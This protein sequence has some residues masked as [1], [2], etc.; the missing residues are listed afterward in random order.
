MTTFFNF[1]KTSEFLQRCLFFHD[2]ASSE[3]LCLS[4]EEPRFWILNGG[5][6]GSSY[7]AKLIQNNGFD[8]CYHEF[9]LR[10]GEYDLD[11]QEEGVRYYVGDMSRSEIMNILYLTR[12][13]IKIECS[14]RLFAFAKELKL[15]FPNS[16]FLHLVRSS[17][18]RLNSSLSLD[19][20]GTETE[21]RRLAYVTHLNGPIGADAFERL[22]YFWKNYNDRIIRDTEDLNCEVLKFEDLIAGRIGKLNEFL[23]ADLS[24]NKIDPVNVSSRKK[25]PM[26]LSDWTPKMISQWKEI[27]LT[28]H[29]RLGYENPF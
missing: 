12:S 24:I 26:S 11:L 8:R 2:Q 9:A 5:G 1:D 27:C 6:C 28:T 22:C 13:H 16:K 7:L 25:K 14:N 20:Y 17:I 15:T 19:L 10:L 3:N 18:D 21:S 23:G 29:L 4:R